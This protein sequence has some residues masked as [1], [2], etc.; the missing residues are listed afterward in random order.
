MLLKKLLDGGFL[1][2]VLSRKF[3]ITYPENVEIFYGDLT[4]KKFDFLNLVLGIDIVVNCAGNN[5]K[6]SLMNSLNIEATKKLVDSTLKS[7]VIENKKK[8]F[9]QLSSIGVYGNSNSILIDENSALKPTS[10][11]ERS[12]AY[13]DQIIIN[14]LRKSSVTFSILRPSIVVGLDMKNAPFFNLLKA[15][16]NRLFF[17]VD[18]KE[19]ISNYVH[20]DDVTNA[21]LECIVNKRARNEIFNISNDCKLSEIVFAISPEKNFLNYRFCLP[22]NL[23]LN[24]IN[25]LSTFIN[26]PLNKRNINF[27]TRKT[28]FPV[29]KLEKTLNFNLKNSIPEFCRIYLTEINARNHNE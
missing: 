23:V 13:A 22:K 4:K 29:G 12:K 28:T 16:K 25:I 18:S 17:Y 8:H 9:V 2:R 14:A 26:L 7:S 27:L 6:S 21:L 20:V 3:P 15:I 1:V 11:Y 5:T 10:A 19:T 24:I